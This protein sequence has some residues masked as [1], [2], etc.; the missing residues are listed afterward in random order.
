MQARPTR[1]RS[2][3]RATAL[4]IIRQ[5]T[6]ELAGGG[7]QSDWFGLYLDHGNGWI[8][9]QIHGWLYL[10]ADANDGIWAWD[11]KRGW[12]WSTKELDPFIYQSNTAS[13]LYLLGVVNGQ[14]VFFDYGTNS[15]DY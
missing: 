1:L 5:N 2:L 9:H 8:Y 3:H 4:S 6:I 14:A 10:A 13:W 11:Q 15:L 12:F 7:R